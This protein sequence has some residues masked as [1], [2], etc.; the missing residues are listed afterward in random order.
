MLLLTFSWNNQLQFA[1]LYVNHLLVG[2]QPMAV[3]R[4]IFCCTLIRK[5][6]NEPERFLISSKHIDLDLYFPNTFQMEFSILGHCADIYSYTTYK[7][8]TKIL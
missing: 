8:N 1:N 4:V 3:A 5:N 2:M 7:L 6:N